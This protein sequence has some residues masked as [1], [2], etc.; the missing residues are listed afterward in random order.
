MRYTSNLAAIAACKSL[1][2]STRLPHQRKGAA[3][4]FGVFLLAGLLIMSAVAVDFGRIS[5]SRS[6]I[7][8][9][10][11]SA[12]MSGAWE[13]FDAA[14][15]GQ[16]PSA[17]QSSVSEMASL[18]AAKNT[19]ASNVPTVNEQTDIEMGYYDMEAG[20]LDT[21]NPDYNAVRV[22]V[23]QRE[24]DGSG[25]SLFF[26]AVTGRH[27]QSLEARSTAAL[28][29]KIGGFYR[30]KKS[31]ETL[32]I[33]PIALDLETWEKVIAKQTE[34][35]LGYSNGQVTNGA[36][37]YFEC[38]LYPTGTGSPG[39]RGTVDIGSANNSTSDL[40]R[41]ILHGI[42]QQD[43]VDLGKPLAFDSNHE[44]QL[45]GDTGISAG[46]KAQLAEIIG[47]PRIIPIFTTVHGNGNNAMYTI[48]RFEGIRI[49]G[50]KLTGPMKKKHVTIQPAP[51]VA[52]H[53]IIEEEIIESEYLFTPVMLVE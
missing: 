37:G 5:V 34:D 23:R 14:V 20:L 41:Q 21:S 25:I 42:S 13:L 47:Q 45:N 44:L 10:A 19:V 49:L 7:K 12:A 27:K 26:G 15:E 51:T 18:F 46:I 50:V 22:H 29:K 38:S 17:A 9:T 6:E 1:R 24:A 52:H 16:T 8:R 31:G 33:L 39:N 36:D 53:S 28:F 30:P 43:L 48:V 4:V 40:R 32:N 11:D 2:Y 3:A 35:K